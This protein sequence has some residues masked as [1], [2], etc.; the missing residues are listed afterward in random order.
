[1]WDN[2]YISLFLYFIIYSMIGWL[3][4][5]V[6]CLLHGDGFINR[7][8]LHGPYCPVYGFGVILTVVLLAPFM[9]NPF[10]VF[11]LTII[12]VSIVEYITSLLLEKA[13][14]TRLW[15]YS[16]YRFNLNGRVCLHH[17]LLFG[18]GGL[19]V[20]YIFHPFISGLI[21]SLPHQ[22]LWGISISLAAVFLTDT[23]VS[24]MAIIDLNIHLKRIETTL[25]E[26]TKWPLQQIKEL[27]LAEDLPRVA[28]IKA[29]LEK[30]NLKLKEFRESNKWY[31]KRLFKAFPTLRSIKYPEH[32]EDLRDHCQNNNQY[33]YKRGVR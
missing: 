6:Y 33:K 22:M 4:E 9:A 5:V 20:L 29:N 13:F 28:E 2:G 25:N 14:N 3:S 18:L 31:L 23:A 21:G 11:L 19:T 32:L 16:N 12:L 24:V 30:L 26:I 1:M 15:D 17:S 8:F 27:E 7:G 10:L